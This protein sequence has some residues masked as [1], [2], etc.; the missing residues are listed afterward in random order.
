MDWPN[1]LIDALARRRAVV[2]IGSGVSANSR[3]VDGVS[4]P[5]WGEFLNRAR[6][7]LPRNRAYINSALKRYKY[8]E[9]CEFLK[10]EMAERWP[11]LIREQFVAPNFS[12]AKIHRAIFDLDSRVV[13]SL[14][15]DKIYETYAIRASQNTVIV[16]NYYDEEIR[17]VV[18]GT[19]RY[20][21]KPHGTVD[22]I[23]QMIFTI[24]DYARARVEHA[25]FYEILTAL[26]HTHV[27]LCVGCGLSDPDMQVIFEDYRYKHRESPH[28]I[29]LPTP[30]SDAEKALLR[31][32]RGLNV[33]LYSPKDNHKALTDEI[34]KLVSIVSIRRDEI[35]KNQNW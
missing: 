6:S 5:T 4:P 17:Q 7:R 10:E 14:N 31:K 27:F 33:L 26:L 13:I 35:A 15:F 9:A 8:L 19:D 28:Y 25:P 2:L 12:D 32:T 24:D 30:F 34:E 22:S 20:I 21:I 18:I 16:K 29:M 3:N 23:R 11:D 1:N